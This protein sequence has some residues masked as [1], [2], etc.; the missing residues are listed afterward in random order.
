MSN[1]ASSKYAANG[2]AQRVASSANYAPVKS[3]P[4]NYLPCRATGLS[5]KKQPEAACEVLSRA[6]K[7]FGLE[8]EV[9]RYRFILHWDKIVGEV[10]AQ[11]SKP[12]CLRNGVLVVRVID[13]VWAQEL[14]FHKQKILKNL[15]AFFSAEEAPQDIYFYAA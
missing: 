10:V 4:A 2:R 9:Q 1:A 3:A 8:K 6:L 5:R 7:R 15:Q 13:S 11:R 12:E 14:I